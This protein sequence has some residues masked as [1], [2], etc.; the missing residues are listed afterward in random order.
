MLK[1]LRPKPNFGDLS[2]FVVSK[3]DDTNYE[4]IQKERDVIDVEKS[5]PI[6]Q[7]HGLGVYENGPENFLD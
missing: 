7:T 2:N 3:E 4:K 1:G 6:E 5:F